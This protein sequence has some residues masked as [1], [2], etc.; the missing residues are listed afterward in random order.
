MHQ[1]EAI[2]LGKKTSI[3]LLFQTNYNLFFVFC[4]FQNNLIENALCHHYT[5]KNLKSIGLGTVQHII[6]LASK[7]S[8]PAS[9]VFYEAALCS[10]ER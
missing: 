8:Y 5:V 2:S 9:H 4:Y 1:S 7:R 3:E 6:D 10:Q